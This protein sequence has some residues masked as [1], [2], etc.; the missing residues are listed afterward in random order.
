MK[1]I[2]GMC[3]AHG[4]GKTTLIKALSHEISVPVLTSS[5]SAMWKKYDI[6]NFEVLPKDVRSV[7]QNIGILE[8]IHQEDTFEHDTYIADRTILDYLMYTTSSSSLSG[9]DLDVHIA[10]IKERMKVYHKFIFIKPHPSITDIVSKE[11]KLIRADL[12]LQSQNTETALEY[13]HKWD[14][15]YLLI[16]EFDLDKRVVKCREYISADI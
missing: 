7:F 8:H 10:L 14:V 15:P 13:L 2:I 3:G 4:T 5:S 16:D 11:T 6:T 9:V 12:D 1:K